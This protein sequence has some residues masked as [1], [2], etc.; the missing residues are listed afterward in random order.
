MSTLKGHLK[1]VPPRAVPEANGLEEFLTN[2][3]DYDH[4]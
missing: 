4:G 3:E 1:H 2:E